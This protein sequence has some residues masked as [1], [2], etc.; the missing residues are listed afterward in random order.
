MF[1]AFSA[2]LFI[3]L[4]KKRAKYFRLSAVIAMVIIIS[5]GLGILTELMQFLIVPLNRSGNFGDLLSDFLG[6]IVGTA[7]IA[8]IKRKSSFAP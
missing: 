4:T 8:V 6:S 7:L 1:F 3:D 2:A 5:V